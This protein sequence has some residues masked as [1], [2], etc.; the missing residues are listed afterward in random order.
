MPLICYL[1]KRFTPTSQRITNVS[2][3]WDAVIEYINAG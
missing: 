1:K 2:D 3:R